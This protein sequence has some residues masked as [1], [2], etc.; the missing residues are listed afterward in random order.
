MSKTKN[1]NNTDLFETLVVMEPETSGDGV[2]DDDFGFAFNDS[3]FSDR[4]LRIEVMEDPIETHTDT[5]SDWSHRKRRREDIQ[6]ENGLQSF[7][8]F[9][10]VSF[11]FVFYLW[12]FRVVYL[13]I[14]I[15]SSRVSILCYQ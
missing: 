6:K 13:F 5:I 14:F 7:T 8:T 12:R 2:Y 10:L 1:L 9:N 11:F 4:I 15:S 3:N